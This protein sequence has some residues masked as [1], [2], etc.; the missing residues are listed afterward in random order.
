MN[1]TEIA[2]R[3]GLKPHPEGGYFRETYLSTPTI[4]SIQSGDGRV[5][6]DRA[7]ATAI[8]YLVTPDSF[9]ALH[10]V[11]SD[12][13]FHFYF[14]DPVEM[15][16][17]KPNGDH[18]LIVLGSHIISGQHPKFTVPAGNWQ[19]ARL[20]ETSSKYALLGTTVY[21][22]FDFS[23]FEMGD[24]GDLTQRFQH[25]SSLIER[26]RKSF[27]FLGSVIESSMRSIDRRLRSRAFLIGFTARWVRF[28]W[29]SLRDGE[30]R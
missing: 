16:L 3:L 7:V 6:K 2:K 28:D 12:E 22:G 18:E 11:A 29:Q 13:T 25:I 4:P 21:P 17:I 14:G 20:A 19:S 30:D 26:V 5:L 8:Y 24:R 23:D 15:L 10:K 9:S 27:T 1:A